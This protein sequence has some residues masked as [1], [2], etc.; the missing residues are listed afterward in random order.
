MTIAN[1]RRIKV[2][3]KQKRKHAFTDGEKQLSTVLA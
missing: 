2:V 1:S 3:I